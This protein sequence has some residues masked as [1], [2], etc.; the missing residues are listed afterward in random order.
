M[1]EICFG[2]FSR[3]KN[4]HLAALPIWLLRAQRETHCG[5]TVE[6]RDMRIAP[7]GRGDQVHLFMSFDQSRIS[8]SLGARLELLLNREKAQFCRA[9]TT[10]DRGMRIAPF[11]RGGQVHVFMSFD[12]RRKYDTL[13][14]S[15]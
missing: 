9:K 15:L 5:R 11:G 4:G 10:A 12:Q 3:S 1:P 2:F 6:D 7:D 8:N 14:A 13:V